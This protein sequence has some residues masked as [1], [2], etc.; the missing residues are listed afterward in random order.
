MIP[1][2]ASSCTARYSFV[3]EFSLNLT[4]LCISRIYIDWASTF[5][6]AFPFHDWNRSFFVQF[7]QNYG[8][9]FDKLRSQWEIFSCGFHPET[10]LL[11]PWELWR[12]LKVKHLE[13]IRFHDARWLPMDVKLKKCL[14]Q[15]KGAIINQ[16]FRWIN[17]FF[18]Q[19]TYPKLGLEC[20]KD[21]PY[22]NVWIK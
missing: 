10:L 14:F 13:H 12:R 21:H 2:F 15:I 20:F 4:Q 5:W 8:F 9:N 11:P 16:S 6:L 22:R 19:H 3:C 17:R 18:F 1:T 7:Y